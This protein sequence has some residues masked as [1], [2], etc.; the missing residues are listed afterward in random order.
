M[1]EYDL[2]EYIHDAILGLAFEAEGK[3]WTE[4]LCRA[5]S[6]GDG[7]TNG[8]EL[9]DPC[10]TWREGQAPARSTDISDPALAESTAAAARCNGAPPAVASI[11]PVPFYQ[12]KFSPLSPCSS[13]CAA[14]GPGL[15]SKEAVCLELPSTVVDSAKCGTDCAVTTEACYA[16]ECAQPAPTRP[17]TLYQCQR[18]AWLECDCLSRTRHQEAACTSFP[19]GTVVD[20]VMCSGGCERAVESCTC[21]VAASPAPTGAPHPVAERATRQRCRTWCAHGAIPE[22]SM[23]PRSDLS[24]AARQPKQRSSDALSMPHAS[25]MCMQSYACFCF[26][27][28]ATLGVPVVA[29]LM[30]VQHFCSYSALPCTVVA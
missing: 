21:D 25:H 4:A 15:R 7:L 1:D 22:P 13:K 17:M 14:D 12:C 9:G 28:L 3:R 24:L 16:P 10:C 8:E 20:S 30:D 11:A 27:F 18:T 29:C 2:C 19:A 23:E 6:D 26:I 5:D